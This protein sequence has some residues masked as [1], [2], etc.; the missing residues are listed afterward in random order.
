MKIE[1]LSEYVGIRLESENRSNVMDV[2]PEQVKSHYREH[3]AVLLRNFDIDADTFEAFTNQFSDDYMDNQGSGSLRETINKKG[4]GT[5][6]SV[7]YAVG[8]KTQLN[9]GLPLHADRSYIADQPE[10]MWF[11]CVRPADSEGE[12]T[13]CDGVRLCEEFSP[14][15]RELFTTTDIK[16]LR[17]YPSGDWQKL[18]HTDDVDEVRRLCEINELELEFSEDDTMHTV[19]T[20]RAITKSKYGNHDTFNNSILIVQWQ[21][22]DLDRKVS[23]VRMADGSR[24]PDEVLADVRRA[25]DKVTYAVSWQP[26]DL[27]MIDNTRLL[28]GRNQFADPERTI[29][30]R[31]CR[32]VDW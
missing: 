19:Y 20:T 27:V 2:D 25:A 28:H 15:T 29:Y 30:V 6:Q 24:I 1:P 23:F 16:Y 22:D 32:S 13:L 21:E 3:G 10:L 7:S 12:T 26:G 11:Y 4:D 17:H 14:A 8:R 31:M 5:I 18:Y 9:F